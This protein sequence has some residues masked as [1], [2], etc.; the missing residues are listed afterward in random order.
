MRLKSYFSGTVE[1][2]IELAKREMGEDALLVNARPAT[3][4]T[5]HLGAYEVVF[6]IPGD[7]LS[8]NSVSAGRRPLAETP[9][10]AVLPESRRGAVAQAPVTTLEQSASGVRAS[11]RY[12]QFVAAELDPTLA[13]DLAQGRSFEDVFTTDATLGCPGAKSSVI[14]LIGPPGS[15]KSTTIAKLARRYGAAEN[16]DTRILSLRRNGSIFDSE[17]PVAPFHPRLSHQD[18]ETPAELVK[19]LESHRS[20]QG[21][22]PARTLIDMP[23]FTRSERSSAQEIAGIASGH[24]EIDTHLVIPA[25][26]KMNAAE[27][28]VEDYAD[29]AP[30][31]LLFTRMDETSLYGSLISLA[32]RTALPISFLTWGR[33][34]PE[35]LEPAT[36]RRLVELVTAGLT[37]GPRSEYVHRKGAAA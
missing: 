29:F 33:R 31:K 11:V 16:R 1:A 24:P 4:E 6:G 3:L 5:R 20:P 15:G 19:A 28:I 8:R 21:S 37:A 27:R 30:R 36:R 22:L 14:L 7:Q 18:F 25:S 32:F 12:E 35:D 26:A 9:L 10:A 34:V 2:A 13:H 23:G 17:M